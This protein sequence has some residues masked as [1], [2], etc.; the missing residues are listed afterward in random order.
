MAKQH[1][2]RGNVIMCEATRL[3]GMIP[4]LLIN[5][6]DEGSDSWIDKNGTVY[7]KSELRKKYDKFYAM[8]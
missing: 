4:P 3:V 6:W 5:F 8:R 1:L 2:K 7:Q